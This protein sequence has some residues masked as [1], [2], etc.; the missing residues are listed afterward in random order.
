[1]STLAVNTIQAQTGSTV[2]VP[3]GQKIVATDQA[4]FV[5]PK[6]IIQY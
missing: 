3:S 6:Q 4:S 5:A 1:M 2:S